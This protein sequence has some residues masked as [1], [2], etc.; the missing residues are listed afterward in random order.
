MVNSMLN[1]GTNTQ[2]WN[3]QKTVAADGRGW[4]G[5]QS[6]VAG[7]WPGRQMWPGGGRAV[8]CGRE[9]AGPP[10]VVVRQPGYHRWPGC[11]WALKCGRS[12][13]FGQ[14]AARLSYVAQRQPGRHMWSGGGR[15]VIGCPE[16]AGPRFP[17]LYLMTVERIKWLR[18]HEFHL[19]LHYFWF[20]DLLRA[21]WSPQT[22]DRSWT[23]TGDNYL[24]GPWIKILHVDQVIT[25]HLV[26]FKR[27][28]LWAV[29][30]EAKLLKYFIERV[31]CKSLKAHLSMQKEKLRS[32]TCW[33]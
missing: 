9:A 5:R 22:I 1:L 32:K 13:I 18:I 23:S 14:E 19:Q 24:L 4:C 30:D 3:K 26:Q 20:F 25:V 6:N 7:R 28:I 2:T 27:F 33:K 16:A 31:K 12:V 21:Q 11:G 15:A 29:C 17:H 8:R 10:D